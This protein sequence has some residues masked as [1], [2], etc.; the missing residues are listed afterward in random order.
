MYRN[1]GIDPEQWTVDDLQ[2]RPRYLI[3]NDRYGVMREL[4]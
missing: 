4:V 1:L 3:D 2:G